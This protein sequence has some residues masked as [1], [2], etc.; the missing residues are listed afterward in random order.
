MVLGTILYEGIDLT[1]HALKLG[2]YGASSVY[3]Y[4]WGAKKEMSTEEMQE[5]IKDLQQKIEKMEAEQKIM[6]KGESTKAFTNEEIQKIRL[7]L[8][9]RTV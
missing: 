5:M 3:G 8:S 4:F 2:Y 1:Y 9:S 6:E 7:A